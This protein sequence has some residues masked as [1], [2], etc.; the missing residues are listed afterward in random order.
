MQNNIAQ[1]KYKAQFPLESLSADLLK[2]FKLKGVSIFGTGN[3]GAIVISALKER[4]IKVNY[5][6]DNNFE[7]IGK[8][9]Q[10]VLII[11]AKELKEKYYN[12]NVIIASLNH[13]YLK[14]QLDDLGFKNYF[15]VDF[16]FNDI[17]FDK[18]VGNTWN[19]ERILKQLDLLNFSLNASRSSKI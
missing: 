8:K 11:S 17:N 3:Y 2:E 1:N 10:D 13:R 15:D 18:I 19:N 5:F 7:S 6:I 14:R 12:E 4:G 9:F 16:L